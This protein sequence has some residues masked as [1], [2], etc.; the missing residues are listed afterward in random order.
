[1]KSDPHKCL[2]LVQRSPWP[3]S[4]I[5]KASLNKFILK[6]KKEKEKKG[7]GGGILRSKPKKETSEN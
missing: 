1:M 7:E 4:N 5:S 6:G 2:C 3:N